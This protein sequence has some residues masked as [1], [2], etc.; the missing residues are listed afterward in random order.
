V[1]DDSLA[2]AHVAMGT[3]YANG[4]D[5]LNAARELE[6]AIE[7]N[8]GDAEAR[9]NYAY[10]LIDLGRPD[11]AVAEIRRAQELDP[12]NVVMNVDVGEILLFARRYDEAIEA[13]R[14]ALEMDPERANAH[15]RLAWAY[16][17]KGME[18]EAVAEFLRALALAGESAGA[19]AALR[20]AYSSGG[21]RGFWRK[22]IEREL[23]RGYAEPVLMA[24]F[25]M[26]LGNKDQAFAWLDRAYRDRS[27]HLVGLK[28]SSYLDPLRTDL[29]YA[30]LVRRVGLP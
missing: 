25:Y 27:P 24:I 16:V 30:D 12:L 4:W 28:S 1:L 23:G 8:P 18:A 11:E 20:E 19:L 17:S 10:R 14:H 9:H 6:R 5:L 22:R 3:V 7:I 26:Q 15:D 29:R 13:L 21:I 2:E